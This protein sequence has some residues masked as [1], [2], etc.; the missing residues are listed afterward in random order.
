MNC[1]NIKKTNRIGICADGNV[2]EKTLKFLLENF[3][4]DIIWVVCENKESEILQILKKYNFD[5]NNIFLNSDLKNKTTLNKLNKS[6]VDYIILA[7]W[8]HIIKNPILSI[9]NIGILNFHPSLLPYN[10]GKHYNFWTIVENTSFGVTIHFIDEKTDS[11]DIIFQKK[12]K[13]EWTDTG[14]SLYDKAQKTMINLFIKK[15]PEIRAG[16]YTRIKQKLNEGS[17]HFAK[18]LDEASKID[19][20]KKYKARDL[21]N[22]I[23][24]RTFLPHP[25]AWFEEKENI[26]EVRVDIK[27][28]RL[29]DK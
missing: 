20:D 16:N 11:G 12:I 3:R 8:P 17:F 25:A 21:L 10:R 7:W 26:Y 24:A 13:K 14:K 19:L 2:G 15:Y 9:P 5:S 1:E 4:N 27:K 18:E 28:R 29:K 6:N 23:R 22:I